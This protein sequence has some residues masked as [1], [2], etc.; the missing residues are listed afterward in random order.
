[1][2]NTTQPDHTTG[3]DA[4]GH[5]RQV[6]NWQDAHIVDHGGCLWVWQTGRGG[7]YR[8]VHPVYEDF[9][10]YDLGDLYDD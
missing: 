10:L 3:F 9:V 8:L 5:W 4:D 7:G 6:L 2:E 1:M